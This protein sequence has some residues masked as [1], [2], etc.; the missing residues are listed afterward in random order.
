MTTPLLLDW[1]ES[2]ALLGMSERKF[3]DACKEPGF[4]AARALGP[5][6]H[7]WVRTELESYAVTLPI[8]ARQEPP[9]LTEGRKGRLQRRA[10]ALASPSPAP[11]AH[12]PFQTG[13]RFAWRAA[14]STKGG[15]A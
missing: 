6:L 3:R 11:A 12:D 9:E 7:R 14:Q 10:K 13:K 1:R 8:A 5:R 2:A 4:P 15:A